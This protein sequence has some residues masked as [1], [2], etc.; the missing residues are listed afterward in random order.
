MQKKP[1]NI[2]KGNIAH[3]VCGFNWSQNWDLW[4]RNFFYFL[5]FIYLYLLNCFGK[6]EFLLHLWPKILGFCRLLK[7]LFLEFTV[8]PLKYFVIVL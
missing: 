6:L 2:V 3:V 5:F 1:E 4:E 8:L 7:I